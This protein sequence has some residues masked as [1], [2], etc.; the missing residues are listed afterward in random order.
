MQRL[1]TEAEVR[2]LAHN[3]VPLHGQSLAGQKKSVL[4][5]LAPS[6]ES[7]AQEL[8]TKLWGT[9]VAT[10]A[11]ALI[12][13][14]EKCEVT[15]LARYLDQPN[16]RYQMF[17][18]LW[19]LRFQF[20]FV[21]NKH[22]DWKDNNKSV[23]PFVT[24]ASYLTV[25]AD[26]GFRTGAGVL[27]YLT[28]DEVTRFLMPES[29]SNFDTILRV[30][31]DLKAGTARHV[32]GTAQDLN[33]VTDQF[34]VRLCPLFKESSL[35]EF[36]SQRIELSGDSRRTALMTWLRFRRPSVPLER[37]DDRRAF[38]ETAFSSSLQGVAKTLSSD[39]NAVGF[40]I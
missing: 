26:L 30:C 10:R 25:L 14:N 6:N 2:A 1:A 27:S 21:R 8:W 7:Q 16:S 33:D 24:L 35:L 28:Y 4:S 9:I 17:C 22:T 29:D 18:M 34:R 40:T 20:P 31:S 15:M 3:L 13:S 19:G 36:T 37:G 23:Q 39:L 38:F 11:L 5:F 12:D 32:V